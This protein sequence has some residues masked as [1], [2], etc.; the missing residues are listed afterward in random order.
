LAVRKEKL[1]SHCNRDL[2]KKHLEKPLYVINFEEKN[3]NKYPVTLD[4]NALGERI[5]KN[6]LRTSTESERKNLQSAKLIKAEDYLFIRKPTEKE[7]SIKSKKHKEQSKFEILDTVLKRLSIKY[8][9]SQKRLIQIL[10]NVSGSLPDLKKAL[11]GEETKMW[12]DLEDIALRQP[13]TEK[14]YKC[15]LKKKGLT[16]I[17]KRK[18]YLQIT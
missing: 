18:E 10:Q 1:N 2:V 8:N 9:I 5:K 13:T 11:N 12:T 7:S 4:L 17:N 15:L 3:T 6:A 16:A 14:V